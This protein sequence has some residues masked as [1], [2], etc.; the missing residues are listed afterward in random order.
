M[1]LSKPILAIIALFAFTAAYGNYMFA[2][3]LCQDSDMWTLMV[4]ISQLS[5][6]ATQGVQFASFLVAAV[7][8]LVVFIFAQ[9]VIIQG[10]VVPVEK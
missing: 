2:L 10:I 9:R 7:P 4:W 8:T 6:H 5:W 1:K 3:L